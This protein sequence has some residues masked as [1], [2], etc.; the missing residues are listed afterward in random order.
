LII[1]PFIYRIRSLQL[2]LHEENT[3]R[4]KTLICYIW[5]V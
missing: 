4:S 2:T 3:A 5:K 1:L